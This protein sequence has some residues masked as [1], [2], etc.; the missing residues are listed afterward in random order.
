MLIKW[1]ENGNINGEIFLTITLR[2]ELHLQSPG[3]Q[4]CQIVEFDTNTPESCKLSFLA[5]NSIM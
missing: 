4:D 2:Q 1:M 5:A 3:V